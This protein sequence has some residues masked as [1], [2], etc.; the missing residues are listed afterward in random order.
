MT[1]VAMNGILN[2]MPEEEWQ[3]D[4]DIHV[5]RQD[6]NGVDLSLIEY[7]LSWSVPQRLEEHYNA[8]RA[9]EALRKA[10]ERLYGSTRPDL[11]A[12]DRV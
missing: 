3:F 1:A 8:R 12:L 9:A 7:A 4:P 5:P 10:G 11:E 2:H 6:E